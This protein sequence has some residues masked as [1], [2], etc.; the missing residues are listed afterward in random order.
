MK[1][2]NTKAYRGGS[3]S[4]IIPKSVKFSSMISEDVNFAFA[5]LLKKRFIANAKTLFPSFPKC[6]Q[7][8]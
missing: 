3:I 2:E 5:L 4:A 6:S 1:K 7:A 8:I